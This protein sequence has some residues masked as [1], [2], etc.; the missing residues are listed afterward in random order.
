MSSQRLWIATP[1]P[2]FAP[3]RKRLR[4]RF[5][6][7]SFDAE[8]ENFRISKLTTDE[9]AVLASLLGRPRRYSSSL[10]VDVRL[11]DIAFQNAGIAVSLR[12]ALEQ[13]DGPIANLATT[14]LALQTIWSDVLDG[15]THRSVADTDGPR[16]TQAPCRTEP[17]G[18][19]PTPPPG[20]SN[21]AAPARG[22]R[23]QLATEVLGDAHG[24]D[25][26]RPTATLILTVWRRLIARNETNDDAIDPAGETELE[27]G[28]S[29]EHDRDVW[30]KAGVLVNELGTPRPISGPTLAR[31]GESR[32]V[33]G[34]ARLRFAT[35]AIALPAVM[36]CGGSQGLCL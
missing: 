10:Q 30:A 31:H 2:P 12:N 16:V 32:S 36:R 27:P 20:R 11:I 35:V 1:L 7:A 6:R 24:L 4:Q 28:E 8:V 26:G 22:R 25:S 23:S 18:G 15:C 9:H 34:R 19:V 14:R 13:F 3:L 17:D 21:I 5:E 33:A 29:V